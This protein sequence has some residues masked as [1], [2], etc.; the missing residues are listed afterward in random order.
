MPQL[1]DNLL[2]L[3]FLIFLNSNLLLQRLFPIFNINRLLQFNILPETVKK[4]A[5]KRLGLRPRIPSAR[6]FP[7][8]ECYQ[9]QTIDPV[10]CLLCLFCYLAFDG[11]DTR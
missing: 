11:W 4:K 2:F 7:L 3:L 8:P 5:Q 1:A 6:T 10:D 9:T